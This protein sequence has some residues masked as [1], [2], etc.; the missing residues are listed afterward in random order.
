MWPITSLCKTPKE[1]NRHRSP[2]ESIDHQKTLYSMFRSHPWTK[3]M[4]TIMHIMSLAWDKL[5]HSAQ[6]H[7]V[8]DPFLRWSLVSSFEWPTVHTKVKSKIII[9]IFCIKNLTIQ[10]WPTDRIVLTVNWHEVT[11]EMTWSNIKEIAAILSLHGPRIIWQLIALLRM[12][13]FVEKVAYPWALL[14]KKDIN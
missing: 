13:W 7:T 12:T 1:L 6:R 9:M 4:M 11:V 14:T 3:L 8:E 10:W 2:H 5:K